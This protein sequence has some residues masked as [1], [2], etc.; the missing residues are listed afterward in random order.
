MCY[1]FTKNMPDENR[2][3]PL[4]LCFLWVLRIHDL[5]GEFTV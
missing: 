1:L 3:G 2:G 4:E 5:K